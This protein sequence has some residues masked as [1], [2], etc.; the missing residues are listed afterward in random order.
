VA[1]RVLSTFSRATAKFFQ[2][3]KELQTN[4]RAR[5]SATEGVVM[6]V[7]ARASTLAECAA[8]PDCE[9]VL[10]L[11]FL[12]TEYKRPFVHAGCQGWVLK[13]HCCG[14]EFPVRHSE[15]F[16][17]TIEPQRVH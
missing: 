11:S 3:K 1:R 14:N 4:R 6:P 13:C 5:A 8:C 12:P 17:T 9:K 2:P 16:R 15:L 7:E 10:V